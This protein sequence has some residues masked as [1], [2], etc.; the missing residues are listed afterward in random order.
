MAIQ[1]KHQFVSLKGDG[2]DATQVQ[3]SNWNA[4]H[5]F[6]LATGQ[7]VGRLSAGAGAAEEIPISAYMA[8]LLNTADAAALAGILGLFETGDLKYT[9]KA[10]APAGW[11]LM[12]GGTGTPPSTIGNAASGAVLRA[13]ADCLELFKVIYA[14]CDDT[15]APVSG[16]R[17]GNA[18]NDFNSGKTIRIPNPV[19]KSPIGAGTATNTGLTTIARVLG[20]LYGAETVT[21]TAAEMP[22]HFHTASIYDPGHTHPHNAAI[23]T[24]SS[25]PGG[26]FQINGY[27]GASIAAAVTNVRVN[28]SNGLDT[29]NSTG[30]NGA[31]A[32]LHPVLALNCMVK[33]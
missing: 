33:L 14:S 32:N 30:G 20:T 13:N 23:L 22:S 21:L 5:A 24:P 28:S 4:A 18:T 10:T 9:Y 25:T 2:T 11:L 6:T 7:L 15:I 19:G 31:H 26:A 17:T 16:G 8:S 27:G 12:L 3:P 29:T 1:I